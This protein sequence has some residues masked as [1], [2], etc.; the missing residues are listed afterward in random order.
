M[1]NLI[2]KLIKRSMLMQ[3]FLAVF[4]CTVLAVFT[5]Q[6]EEDN[7]TSLVVKLGF[8]IIPDVHTCEGR[9]VSPAIRIE[10]L[11]AASMAVI[12]DDPD[13]PSGT[14]THWIIWNIPPVHA[15][16]GAIARNATLTDPFPALQGMNDFGEIGYVGPCPPPGKPHRYHFRVYGLDRRLDLKAG[17]TLSELRKAMQGHVLQLG[18]AVATYGR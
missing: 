11:N 10:E 16:P 6:A 1:R 4:V 3:T 17:A 13:A 15:I 9:D 8:D 2:M 18:E 5:V 7:M 14:F 12:V